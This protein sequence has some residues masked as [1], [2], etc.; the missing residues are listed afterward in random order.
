MNKINIM[1]DGKQINANPNQ[2]I[3]EAAKEAGIKIPTLC[4]YEH[5][6]PYGSCRLCIVEIDGKKGFPTS[7]TTLVQEGMV[8]RTQSEQINKIRRNILELYLSEHDFDCTTCANN[9]RC[10]L[11]EAASLLGI[12]EI[13]YKSKT[14]IKNVID[15]SNPYFEFDSSKCIMCARCVRA[16]EEIQGN[17]ALTI[18]ARGFD[19]YVSPGDRKSVV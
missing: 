11:Q 4:A 14:H 10:E 6:K 9:L 19:S 17:F 2:T 8:I 16:C 7:C 5:T 12:R 1:I 13:R 15:S 3:L 18:M